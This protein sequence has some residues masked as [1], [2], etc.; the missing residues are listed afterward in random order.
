[1]ALRSARLARCPW[2][3]PLSTSG[4][5]SEASAEETSGEESSAPALLAT[6]DM[7]CHFS[8]AGDAAPGFL[9]AVVFCH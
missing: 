6:S 9:G 5:E 4:S 1:M 7:V 8:R 3:L 2:V